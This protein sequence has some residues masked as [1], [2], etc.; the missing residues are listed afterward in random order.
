MILGS[1][2]YLHGITISDALNET[3][4]C[5]KGYNL[6]EANQYANEHGSV[7]DSY[8]LFNY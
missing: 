7:S 3:G 2:T 8:V 6:I 1:S 4:V 5:L